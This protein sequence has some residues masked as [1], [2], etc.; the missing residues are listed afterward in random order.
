MTEAIHQTLLAQPFMGLLLVVLL[1]WLEYVFPPV[2]GD[3]TMLLACFLA[4]AGLLPIWATVCGCLAGSVLGAVTAYGLG[5]RLGRSYFFLRSAWAR[6]ELERLDRGLRRFGPKLLL[7]N[8]FL[9]GIRAVFLYGAGI[10]RVPLR[11]VLLYSTVSNVLWVGLIAWAGT[12]LGSSWEE[13]QGV[14]RRYLYA[15]GI[16]LSA[17]VVWSVLRARRRARRRLSSS[18]T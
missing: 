5:T 15:L 6:E 11:P 14:F 18:S 3:T 2:P 16:G 12:G 10:G 4:G 17:Y 1:A 8:R 7:L 9:P 13:V